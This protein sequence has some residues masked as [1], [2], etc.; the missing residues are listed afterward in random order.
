MVHYQ[1]TNLCIKSHGKAGNEE[2]RR[3]CRFG[4]TYCFVTLRRGPDLILVPVPG[5]ALN[6]PAQAVRGGVLEDVLELEKTF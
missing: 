1:K 2:R 3:K 6:G 5:L 4:L